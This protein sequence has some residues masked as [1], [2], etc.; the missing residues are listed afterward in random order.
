[1]KKIKKYLTKKEKLELI[2][3]SESEVVD[4]LKLAFDKRLKEYQKEKNK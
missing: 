1:M 2:R 3:K 4:K